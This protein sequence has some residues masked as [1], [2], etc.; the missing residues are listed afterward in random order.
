V[1]SSDC[2]ETY[3]AGK[4]RRSV[5][6]GGEEST[7]GGRKCPSA[8]IP[9][10]RVSGARLLTLAAEGSHEIEPGQNSERER[11]RGGG[12]GGG[13][14]DLKSLTTKRR[15]EKREGASCPFPTTDSIKTITMEK[16]RKEGGRIGTS[17]DQSV[18]IAENREM[19]D[20]KGIGERHS[21]KTLSRLHARKIG[22]LNG[23]VRKF[24]KW[25]PAKEKK[26]AAVVKNGKKTSDAPGARER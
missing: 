26:K 2:N 17:A 20:Q 16:G 13:I 8:V 12:G 19:K 4:G 21:K 5:P 6:S 25:R 3:L 9:G 22:G 18:T 10:V 23:D 14:H 15:K 11:G 7:S 1:L 24:Q